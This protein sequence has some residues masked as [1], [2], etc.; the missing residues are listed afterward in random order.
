LGRKIMGRKIIG[1]WLLPWI[2]S[3]YILTKEEMD[4]Y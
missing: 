3:R 1:R 2:Q 4:E